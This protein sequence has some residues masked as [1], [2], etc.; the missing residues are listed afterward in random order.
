SGNFEGANGTSNW[1]YEKCG[2]SSGKH[3]VVAKVSDVEGSSDCRMVEVNIPATFLEETG[4]TI[5]HISRF[6]VYPNEDY[7]DAPSNGFGLC[8]R[9]FVELNNEFGTT[10]TFT[11]YGREDESVWCADPANL[12]ENGITPVPGC[13]EFTSTISTHV[14]NGR[15]YS[16]G[17]WIFK[18]YYT[19]GTDIQLTG[20]SV[21]T[22]TLHENANEPGKFHLGGCN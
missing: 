3:T 4:T 11:I 18:M 12:S 14:A 2:L 7:P 8:D 9:T 20:S 21:T 16:T 1:T 6:N 10:E 19:T 17:W 15:A 5:D 13:E 22:I